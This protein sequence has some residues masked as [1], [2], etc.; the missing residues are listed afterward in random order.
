[1]FNREKLNIINKWWLAIDKKILAVFFLFIIFSCIFIFSSSVSVA[2]RLNINNYHFFKSQIFYSI[3][4]IFI[5]I[6]ISF[7]SEKIAKKNIFLLF[8]LSFILLIAVNFIGF[9]TKG[10]RRWLRIYGLSIQPTELIKPSFILISAWLLE[11][12]QATKIKNYLIINLVL[13]IICLYFIYKQPDIGT[14]ILLSLVFFTQIFLLDFINLKYCLYLFLFFSF[15][16][17]ISYVSLPHVYNRINSFITSIQEPEK[18]NYQVKRSISAYNNSGLL[19]KG[20]MEGEVKNFI[21]D[22]HTDFIFPAITEE[23]GFLFVFFIIS[24]YF[25]LTIRILLKAIASDDFFK[26]LALIGLALL[27]LVQTSINICVSL[28]LLPTKGMT[29]PFLSYGGSSLIGT[30]II[31]GFIFIFTRKNIDFKENIERTVIIN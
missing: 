29:I 31:F 2:N 21:P 4:C 6:S 7:F 24:I 12:F 30:A 25:Y 28:N 16:S 11:R 22:V 20:F 9:Q 15:L 18:A 5:T 10:S 17:L 1:M 3:L 23:F 19:G 14:L 8:I 27:F 13:Y 26:F